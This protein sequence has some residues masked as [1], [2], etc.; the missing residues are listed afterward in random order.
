MLKISAEGASAG[1]LSPLLC[2]C[3]IYLSLDTCLAYSQLNQK[4]RSVQEE[5]VII[6]VSFC[7]LSLEMSQMLKIS[8]EGASAGNLSPLI[9]CLFHKLVEINFVQPIAQSNQI[10]ILDSD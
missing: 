8:A 4:I 5:P 2:N 3:Y 1:N 9:K 10:Q 6:I 7:L